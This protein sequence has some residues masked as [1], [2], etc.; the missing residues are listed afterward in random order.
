MVRLC[1][2]VELSLL[3]V[4][5]KMFNFSAVLFVTANVGVTYRVPPPGILW[6]NAR[7]TTCALYFRQPS[8]AT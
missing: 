3:M 1:A 8:L 6:A 7:L 2:D 4:V 5:L